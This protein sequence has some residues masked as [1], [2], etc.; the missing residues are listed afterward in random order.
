MRMSYDPDLG[1]ELDARNFGV[2]A[3]CGQEKLKKHMFAIYS[4]E[5]FTNPKV[6]GHFCPD[7][8][9]NFLERYDLKN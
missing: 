5:K 7:C 3:D 4:K 2:C 1:R 6:I 9:Y 8:Y